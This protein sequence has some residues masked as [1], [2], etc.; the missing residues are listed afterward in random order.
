MHIDQY[1][2]AYTLDIQEAKKYQV[3]D[4]MPQIH[5]IKQG[6]DPIPKYT[7]LYVNDKQ[8]GKYRLPPCKGTGEVRP[9]YTLETLRNY[10]THSLMTL[11]EGQRSALMVAWVGT[12]KTYIMA[13]A[14]DA[15]PTI[16]IVPYISIWN[17]IIKEFK[18]ISKL[19]NDLCAGY[20][21][22]IRYNYLNK[23]E[24]LTS[25]AVLKRW[26]SL[27]EILIMTRASAYKCW[28]Q[29]MDMWFYKKLLIDEA[30]FL[31]DTIKYMINTFTGSGIIGVTATPIRK[32]L[33]K[34]WFIKY[35]WE[36]KD[37][38][39]ENLPAIILPLVNK[40]EMPMEEYIQLTEGIQDPTSPEALRKIVN[41][42]KGRREKISKFLKDAILK[43]MYNKCIV[44][45]D[46]ITELE[47]YK[48][49]FPLAIPI[50]GID[51]IKPALEEYASRW[52]DKDQVPYVSENILIQ[53]QN[54]IIGMGQCT[55]T[56]FNVPSLTH[57]VL[58]FGTRW[59]PNVEQY[60]WR[61]RRMF[62]NKSF[63]IFIDIQDHFKIGS[64]S[65]DFWSRERLTYYK[66]TKDL[67]LITPD[68][69][70]NRII[71]K[72]ILYRAPYWSGKEPV[73]D[74]INTHFSF[75]IPK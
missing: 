70:F 12:G 3:Q 46:R 9:K 31:S 26:T 38:Q 6:L 54:L 48:K 4:H 33:E 50:S 64:Q 45:V 16:I 61:V 75:E 60:I 59:T 66:N 65:R 44:F 74:Y 25:S 14:V 15:M 37:I 62:S 8:R 51:K 55:G 23:A 71:D 17:N 69:S 10:Q 11:K 34:E 22:S 67:F 13:W 56:G 7:K 57:W 1:G 18:K 68:I 32:D 24:M 49:E 20:P 21:S 73:T 53:W 30:H 72:G 52:L 39:G 29:L 2:R 5:R 19:G 36:Y 40:Y 35:F 47:R 28:D 63:W 58:T 42:A 41:G 43:S 27:P